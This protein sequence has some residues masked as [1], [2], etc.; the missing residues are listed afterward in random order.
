MYIAEN[1]QNMEKI[2]CL[3]A[4]EVLN[5][6]GYGKEFPLNIVPAAFRHSSLLMDTFDP[7]AHGGCAGTLTILNCAAC[8]E[9]KESFPII[10]L[11]ARIFGS[12]LFDG[13]KPTANM[14]K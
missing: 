9:T 2:H 3:P 14:G 1:A 12:G 8:G 11:K 5:S 13:S 6:G 10:A 4:W 7:G